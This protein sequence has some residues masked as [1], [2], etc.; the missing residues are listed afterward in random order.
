MTVQLSESDV[1]YSALFVLTNV[2][3]KGCEVRSRSSSNY[4]LFPNRRGN[5]VLVLE[6]EQW[7]VPV[8]VVFVNSQNVGH[9]DRYTVYVY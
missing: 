8:E 3:I 6:F 5:Q 4:A 9:K 1:P 2:L 7:I